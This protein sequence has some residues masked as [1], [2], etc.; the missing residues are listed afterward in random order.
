MTIDQLISDPELPS[1]PEAVIRLN[2]LISHDASMP[3]IAEVIHRDPSLTLRTLEL[4]NSAW[5]KREKTIE[6]VSEAISIIGLSSLYQLIFATSVT[7]LFKDLET[8]QFSM[9]SFWQESVRTATLMQTLAAYVNEAG[10]SLFTIGL[11]AYIGKLILATTSPFLAYKVYKRYRTD[12]TPLYEIEKDILGFSH[13]DISAAIM[14]KWK[15]P[16]SF[17]TPI[18]YAYHPIDAPKSYI[19]VATLL[20]IAHYLQTTFYPDESGQS[21]PVYE[22][23][24]D[25]IE[26]VNIMSS[27]FQKTVES[28]SHLYDEAII[29]LD[30]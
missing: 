26:S 28:A 18:K 21:A 8:E 29:L 1:L 5:F 4:A 27:E 20:H 10:Q 14:E 19:Q 24:P 7:R 3:Q 9:R 22:L 13:M 6:S 16:E 25:L 23:N 30:L 12:A 17:Y 11:T 2:E 15:L